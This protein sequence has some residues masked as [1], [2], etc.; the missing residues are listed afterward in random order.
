MAQSAEVEDP[1]V[2][3]EAI[4]VRWAVETMARVL[5]WKPVCL[6]QA[7]AAKKMLHRRGI[8]STLYLGVDPARDLDAHAWVRV[9]G[10]IV[11]GG[12]RP[13]RFAVVSTFA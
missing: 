12:P 8:S 10:T 3:R 2:V 13:D 11:T 6:P 1:A 9:G 7:L 4:R 5:P